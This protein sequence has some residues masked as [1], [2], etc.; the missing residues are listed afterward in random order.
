MKVRLIAAAIVVCLGSTAFFFGLRLTVVETPALT[1]LR[2]IIYDAGPVQ[3]IW[4]GFSATVI[5][6]VGPLLA[7]LVIGLVATGA[8]YLIFLFALKLFAKLAKE[9]AETV[10]WPLS[11]AANFGKDIAVGGVD[12]LKNG[13]DAVKDGAGR[14]AGFGADAVKVGVGNVVAV[15]EAGFGFVAAQYGRL[16]P[17][18][19]KPGSP[20]TLHENSDREKT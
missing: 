11:K 19:P 17:S 1:T 3:Q 8:I 13:V 6:Y 5:A 7:L 16:R 20:N 18:E 4:T 12:A 15:K 14:A 2:D 10:L 9:A